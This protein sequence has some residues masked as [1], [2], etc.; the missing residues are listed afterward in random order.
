VLPFV[1]LTLLFL[2]IPS[3]LLVLLGQRGQTLLP[4]VRDW[5]NNNSW[6]VSEVVIGLFVVITA[7]SLAG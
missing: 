5:M 4:K 3:L 2:A 6:I 1:L 7:S